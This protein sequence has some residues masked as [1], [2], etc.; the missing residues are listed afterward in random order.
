MFI[1]EEFNRKV[2]NIRHLIEKFDVPNFECTRLFYD[3]NNIHPCLA[4]VLT[5]D[6]VGCISY[7]KGIKNFCNSLAIKFKQYSVSDAKSL[8]E[9]IYNLNN[10]DEVHGILIMYPTGYGLK[11]TIFMNLVSPEKDVEGL[12][13]SYL[14]YLVQFEK[15]LDAEQLRKLVIPPTAK[16]IL[17]I[18]KRFYID[19]ED[20]YNQRGF[21]PENVENNPFELEGKRVTIINDSLAVGRSLALMLLNENAYVQI[22]HQY[23]PFEKTLE[24]VSL[25]DIVISAVP[26][27][28][29]KIPTKYV[30]QNSILI[31]ISFEGNFD[32]PSVF[33]K[34][35]KIAPRWDLVEKGNRINDMTLNRLVSNLFYLINS[36]L[37]EEELLKMKGKI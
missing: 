26:S 21:Y 17:S 6:D 11:D 31:D 37:P 19:F 23:T 12:S 1:N 13:Y 7:T 35:Y 8:E 14:G 4:V 18:F 28:K 15:F 9:I 32:Y 24:S 20:F 36:K 3:Q 5:N 22:C 34:C 25:S 30:P 27:G 2:L 33:E 10:D 16:G 29:F